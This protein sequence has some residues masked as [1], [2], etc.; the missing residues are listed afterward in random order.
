[1]QENRDEGF[2]VFGKGIWTEV[3][4][5]YTTLEIEFDNL[6]LWNKNITYLKMDIETAE[7]KVLINWINAGLLKNV[8]QIAIEFHRVNSRN[9][10]VY[11]DIVNG[12]YQQGFRLMT[13]EPNYAMWPQR[14]HW[15]SS[16]Y[17]HMFH[18]VTFRKM[19]LYF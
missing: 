17:V 3:S 11:W 4:Y 16:V 8:K 15:T 6:D 10:Q 7:R 18:E 14:M 13:F 1:M 19:D 9:V 12:L 2:Y 5:Q